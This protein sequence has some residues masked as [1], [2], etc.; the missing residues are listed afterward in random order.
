MY[1]KKTFKHGETSHDLIIR[2]DKIAIPSTLQTPVVE[3]YHAQL[4]HPGEPGPRV[5]L[6]N[7]ST[8]RVCA[9]QYSEYAASASTANYANPNNKNLDWSQRR[10][11]NLSLGMSVASI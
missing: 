11:P 10:Q 8:G 2:E 3:W 4:M 5:P 7:T 9:K 1:D 6:D